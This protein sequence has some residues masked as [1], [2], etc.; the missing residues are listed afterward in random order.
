MS[1]TLRLPPPAVAL[2]IL[3][4]P[5]HGDCAAAV[6]SPMRWS[7]WRIETQ[8]EFYNRVVDEARRLGIAGVKF[9]SSGYAGGLDR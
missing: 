5:G 1:E 3:G 8:A 2:A 4:S 6:S 7:R 9:A